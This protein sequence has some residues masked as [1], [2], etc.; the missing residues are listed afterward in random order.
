MALMGLGGTLS[1]ADENQRGKN[2]ANGGN[3]GGNN[4]GSGNGN[5]ASTRVRAKHES[6]V[7]QVI[8]ELSGEFR[9]DPG[10]EELRASFESPSIKTGDSVQFCLLQGATTV[11]LGVAK[12]EQE[13][14]GV[15][16]A[17]LEFDIAGIVGL[18]LTNG[19]VSVGD[20]LEVFAGAAGCGGT[21]LDSATFVAH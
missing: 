1:F 5:T 4:G 13:V 8:Q 17:S 11:N 12:A 16:E 14:P 9:T 19:V 3:N 15:G 2:V 7:T 21:P 6:I 20:Q 18:K 10:K